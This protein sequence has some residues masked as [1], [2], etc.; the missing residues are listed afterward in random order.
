MSKRKLWAAEKGDQF[1]VL[2]NSGPMRRGQ[3]LRY[4][5]V[6]REFDGW[7][8]Y[9]DRPVKGRAGVFKVIKGPYRGDIFD[10]RFGKDVLAPYKPRPKGGFKNCIAFK[11]ADKGDMLLKIGRGSRGPKL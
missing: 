2:K 11:C 5:R 3:V 7:S 1:I 9:E 10:F 6:M 8:F 4:L